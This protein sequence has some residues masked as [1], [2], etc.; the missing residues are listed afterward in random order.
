MNIQKVKPPEALELLHAHLAPLSELN[1]DTMCRAINNSDFVWIGEHNGE[2]F[3][4][5][6]L[7]PPTICSD[8]AYL[9]FLHT[10]ALCKCIIPFIRHSRRVTAEL[11]GH[12]PILVGHGKA[13]DSRSLRWLSWCGAQFSA[14]VANG[15]LVPFEIKAS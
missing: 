8:R 12:Y 9:W 2:I 1:L 15:A 13:D 3:G 4:Y 6:G 10:G 11:L 5:W 7:I 14:P